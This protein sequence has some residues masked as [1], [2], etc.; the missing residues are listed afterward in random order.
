MSQ[1]K[2]Y[3]FC[4]H[5]KETDKDGLEQV[6]QTTVKTGAESPKCDGCGL[7]MV[8]GRWSKKYENGG[9]IYTPLYI[10]CD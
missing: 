5:V 9:K 10:K 6:F 4:Y 2:D 7:T 8:Y 3:Y 1:E